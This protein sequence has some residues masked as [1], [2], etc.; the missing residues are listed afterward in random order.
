MTALREIAVSVPPAVPLE[1]LADKLGLSALDVRVF[2]R[3]HGLDRIAM[4]TPV[5]AAGPASGW[6]DL[7]VTAAAGLAGLGSDAKRVRYVLAAR[8]V[9][10]A[11]LTS[12]FP[13]RDVCTRLG[14]PDATSFIV[15]EHACASGLLA[16]D[17]AGRLLAR[18]GEP[19]GLALILAGELAPTAEV[20][21]IA[22]TTIMAEGTA[23][24]LVAADGERDRLLSYVSR[25]PDP[26]A[27]S[28]EDAYPDLFAGVLSAAVHEAGLG[29]DDI[30]LVLPH[31]VNRVSWIRVARLLDLPEDRIYLDNVAAYGHSFSADSFVNYVGAVGGD[32]LRDGDAYVMAAAG[33][34]AVASAMV[35]RH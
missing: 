35:L 24:V 17:L 5:G 26:A 4:A 14:L 2:R 31:N 16:V 21:L 32:R 29:W 33:I 13:L 28:F 30:A 9:L 22:N 19:D 27:G 20:Q 8:S 10:P 23:A 34:G 6:V 7:V 11:S 3:L 15:A 1:D 25:A 12:A 18:D